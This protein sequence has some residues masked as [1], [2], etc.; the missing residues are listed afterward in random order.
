MSNPFHGGYYSKF[1]E[2]L[3]AERDAYYMYM[4]TNKL[5]IL[6]ILIFIQHFFS[7]AYA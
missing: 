7:Y 4:A 6:D 2:Q 3:S 5:I 1:D